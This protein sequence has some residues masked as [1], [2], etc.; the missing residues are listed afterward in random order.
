M[1]LTAALLAGGV[2]LVGCAASYAGTTASSP[3]PSA[4]VSVE[5]T[6]TP[7]TDGRF[8]PDQIA[9]VVTSDLVV[10]STPGTGDESEIYPGRYDVPMAVFVIDGPVFADGYEWYLV[11]AVRGQTIGEYPQPGWVAAAGD[12]LN[13]EPQRAL[14]CYRDT[15]LTVEGTLTGCEPSVAYGSQAWATHCGL[16]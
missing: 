12:L 3:S 1:R 16:V 4:N 2:I 7:G 9:A 6:R 14:A 15:T 8:A 10:R 5:P 13:L 11:E